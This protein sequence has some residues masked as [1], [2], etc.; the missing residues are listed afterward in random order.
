MSK[1]TEVPRET[2]PTVRPL[3]FRKEMRLAAE[4]GIKRVTRRIITAG[5]S[6]VTPGE[7]AGLRLETGRV[8]APL[9]LERVP[10][11]AKKATLRAM[12]TRFLR[13]QCEFDSGRVRVVSVLPQV[14]PGDLFYVKANRYTSRAKS[15]LTL[16]VL[17]V[18]VSRLQDMTNADAEAEGV[19]VLD[20]PALAPRDAFAILWDT[21][22]GPGAWKAN[23]WVWSYVFQPIAKNVDRCLE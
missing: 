15:T 1:R 7:F 13:C 19:A 5:N 12:P 21:I 3:L 20:L 8:R 10:G 17:S 22:N 6:R 4:Q 14:I 23:P 2:T 9:R 16:A 18:G 11:T